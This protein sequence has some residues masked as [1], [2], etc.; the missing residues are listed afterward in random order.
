MIIP[1]R[2]FTCNK[3]IGNKIETYETMKK[4]NKSHK[5]IFDALGLRRICCKRMITTHYDITDHHQPRYQHFQIPSP[6]AP[7]PSPS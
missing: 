3:V 1:V 4:D 5:E 2:C 7:E 6:P